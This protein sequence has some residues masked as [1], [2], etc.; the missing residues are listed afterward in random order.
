MAGLH[1]TPTT[2]LV[3]RLVVEESNHACDPVR[4]LY[5]SLMARIVQ[6]LMRSHESV[7]LNHAQVSAH[8]HVHVHCI[9]KG[10]LIVLFT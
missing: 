1:R 8:E 6:E 5:L 3:A 7:T 2:R 4:I 10:Y 9:I